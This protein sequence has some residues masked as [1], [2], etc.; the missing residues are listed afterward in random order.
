LAGSVRAAVIGPPVLR[1][2]WTVVVWK[3]AV[4]PPKMKSTVPSM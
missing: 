1:R 4:P 2:S 3:T